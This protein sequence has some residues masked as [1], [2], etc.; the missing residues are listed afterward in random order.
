[1]CVTLTTGTQLTLGSVSIAGT[2]A[3]SW[4]DTSDISDAR[5]AS[6]PITS[7]PST[8]DVS[9]VLL[10]EPGSLF[11]WSMQFCKTTTLITA[12]PS[13]DMNQGS[14]ITILHSTK[15][16]TTSYRFTSLQ[17]LKSWKSFPNIPV[18]VAPLAMH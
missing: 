10:K 15:I 12:V 18:T 7:F 13:H 6:I 16:I 2:V 14:I 5:S 1:M 11:S 4:S 17:H 3:V 8:V 9:H